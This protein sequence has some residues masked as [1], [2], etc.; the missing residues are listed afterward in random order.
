MYVCFIVDLAL[1]RLFL[2]ENTAAFASLKV[3]AVNM[4]KLGM[5]HALDQGITGDMAALFCLYSLTPKPPVVQAFTGAALHGMAG[6][7]NVQIK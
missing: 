6:A 5:G 1:A 2:L 4:A 7:C 3:G